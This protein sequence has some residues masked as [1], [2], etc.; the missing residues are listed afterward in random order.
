MRTESNTLPAQ[1]QPTSSPPSPDQ[2]AFLVT[3]EAV[4]Q[5]VIESDRMLDI[6]D[7]VLR[8]PF[9]RKIVL[10]MIHERRIPALNL[11]GKWVITR[12]HFLKAMESGFQIPGG[13]VRSIG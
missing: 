4:A 2:N 5:A 11:N 8:L 12:S 7:M 3:A 9:S 13:R 6:N 1:S 10:R